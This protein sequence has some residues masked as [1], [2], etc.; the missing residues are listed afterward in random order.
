LKA[1]TGERN[2]RVKNS[3]NFNESMMKE[4]EAH[5]IAMLLN[6][7]NHLMVKHSQKT[8]LDHKDNYVFLT[9]TDTVIACAEA[10]KV[11]WY[12]WE[13]SHVSVHSKHEG[14]GKGSAILQL[15]EEKA[16]K[17]EALVLQCTIRIDNKD[18]IRLFSRNGYKQVNEFRNEESG[19][20]LY[21]YQKIIRTK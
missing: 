3:Y 7:R 11:Q 1:E 8:V 2:A 21:I 6:E 12:Q 16:I 18:S 20:Q 10:K 15:A 19:N 4:S 13:I 5:Q 14:K 9:D 17:G